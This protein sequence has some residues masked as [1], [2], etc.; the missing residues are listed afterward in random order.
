MGSVKARCPPF[1][2]GGQVAAIRYEGAMDRHK[3]AHPEVREGQRGVGAVLVLL[4]EDGE[5]IH[6]N[7]LVHDGQPG[8]GL[9]QRLDGPHEGGA[10]LDPVHGV[11]AATCTG[12]HP[13]GGGLPGHHGARL[14]LG[15]ADRLA[16]Q[17]DRS[18]SD[19]E[20]GVVDLGG[21]AG[22]CHDPGHYA[23][24]GDGRQGVT[25]L[26]G[27]PAATPTGQREAGY[28]NCQ[29]GEFSH[30]DPLISG[31]RSQP[32]PEGLGLRRTQFKDCAR[33]NQRT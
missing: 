4:G 14:N 11:G 1:H 25:R 19:T 26:G 13:T 24:R 12:A 18:P 27:G 20:G 28:Q 5:G 3:A 29:N 9:I 23:R 7:H 6:L 33:T 17:G 31:S 10:E 32:G 30:G 21:F 2:A 8:G 15:G 16:I 22:P